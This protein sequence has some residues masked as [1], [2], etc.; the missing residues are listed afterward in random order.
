MSTSSTSRRSRRRWRSRRGLLIPTGEAVAESIATIPNGMPW[1]WAALRTMPA[2]RGERI[3]FLDDVETDRLGLAGIGQFPSL[4]LLPGVDVTVG[5]DVDV[6][7]VT[8]S[9]TELDAW[10]MTLEHLLPVAM[11]NLRRAVGTWAGGTNE[12]DYHGTPVRMLEG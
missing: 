4:E 11:G 2:V 3:A 9:Q 8:V 10:D 12:D 1:A 5:I 7:R 6:V